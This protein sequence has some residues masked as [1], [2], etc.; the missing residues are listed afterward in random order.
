M[1]KRLNK[2]LFL[3]FLI[4]FLINFVSAGV[5]FSELNTKYNLGDMI[6][7]NVKVDPVKEGLL[8]NV[9]LYCNN[10]F[11]IEFNNLPSSDGKVNIKLP[12]NFNTINRANGDCYFTGAY[13]GESW[14]SINFEI[15]KLLIVISFS[16]L[17][18][19]IG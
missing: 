7:F 8:L 13:N 17:S 9:K 6:D 19:G 14:N 1:K 18:I 12:L 2:I 15:S 10:V 5:Y 11:V 3:A 16:V 4:I